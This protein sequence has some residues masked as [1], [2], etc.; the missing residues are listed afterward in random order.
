[1]GAGYAAGPL[2]IVGTSGWAPFSVG[3]G[4][5][6]LCAV[7]LR[8]ASSKRSGFEDDGQPAGSS[9]GFARLAPALLAVLV[10]FALYRSS[11]RRASCHGSGWSKR[12]PPA[13]PTAVWPNR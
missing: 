4:G 2:T 1:M 12:F 8:L 10:V 13:G 5:F 11:Q 3:I 7:I 6:V 9:I